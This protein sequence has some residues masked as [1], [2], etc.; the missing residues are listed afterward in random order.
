VQLASVIALG[1]LM[2]NALIHQQPLLTWM[3]MLFHQEKSV[4]HANDHIMKMFLK[5]VFCQGQGKG[6][7]FKVVP[8]M[9]WMK[10]QGMLM[11]ILIGCPLQLEDH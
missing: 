8:P 9:N 10:I 4:L 3:R 5:S 6:Q 1:K 2:K 7:Q 11:L